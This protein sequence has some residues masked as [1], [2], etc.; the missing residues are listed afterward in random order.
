MP[1]NTVEYAAAELRSGQKER[2][3]RLFHQA[4]EEGDPRAA[5]ALGFIYESMGATHAES[6][7]Q[8][9]HWYQR[10]LQHQEDENVRLG[11]A[12]HFYFGLGGKRD[13][14]RAHGHLMHVAPDRNIEAALMLAEL[15]LLGAGCTRDIKTARDLFSLAAKRGFPLGTFG[16][17]RVAKREGRH[18]IAAIL[19][20]RYLVA[21][22]WLILRDQT[23]PRLLGIGRGRGRLILEGWTGPLRGAEPEEGPHQ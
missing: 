16:L 1:L 9:A 12:R 17:A 2:A 15:E 8:A 14:Q 6:Y 5:A 23:D 3:L 4:A 20:L 11:M 10:A 22:I 18:L 13:L 7:T 21:S 19:A